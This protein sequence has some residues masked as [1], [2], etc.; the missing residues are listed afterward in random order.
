MKVSEI[1]KILKKEAGTSL[2]TVKNMICIGIQLKTDKSL[3]RDIK[4]RS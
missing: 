1:L 4:A 2:E 3:F